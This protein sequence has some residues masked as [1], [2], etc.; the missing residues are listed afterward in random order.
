MG[1]LYSLIYTLAFILL[2][3]V[4]ALSTIFR[5]KYAAG[6]FQRL[7]YLP[8]FKKDRRRVVWLHCVSVGEVNA[9]RPLVDAIRSEFE[10]HRLI[11][12]TVTRTG[13][14]LAHEIYSDKADSIFYVPF[15]WKFT[16][17]RAIRH[18]SPS[19]LLLMETEI[20]FNLIRE[21]SKAKARIA[22]VNG[23]LSERS[24]KRYGYL[25]KTMRRVLGH[26]DAALMQSNADA[27]RIM[28]LGLRASKVKVSGNLK[29]DHHIEAGESDLANSIR[30]RF[31]ITP[32]AP[33]IIAASTHSPEEKLVLEAFKEVWK[34]SERALPRLML[35]PRHPERFD[36]VA[37]LIRTTGFAWARRSEA[38]STRDAAAEVILLDSIGE[39]RSVYPLAELVFVGGS[40]IPHGGQS[41]FEP[42]AYGRA[43][44]AGPHMSNFA[45]GVRDFLE[46]NA[47]RQLSNVK[48]KH[49]VPELAE[50]FRE[51][52]ADNVGR[53][54]MGHNALTAM[55]TNRGATERTIEYLRSYLRSSR[56]GY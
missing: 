18:F 48:E 43:I 39:L 24:Y 31:E 19:V 8:K 15:D 35:V 38:E 40:L 51:L 30:E 44:I 28:S 21:T 55:N 46:R 29:F 56:S 26:L 6:F 32:E 42:A 36:E 4:F 27:N 5:G 14:K 33:L 13:Q 12:S 20:W 37:D 41:I 17:R 10:E 2:L 47:I 25:K 50:A 9:A 34:S 45:F 54:E 22:I 1:F 7:G 16:V 23:R 52:L 49:I 11:V 3:P 53:A